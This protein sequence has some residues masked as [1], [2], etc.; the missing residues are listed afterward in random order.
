MAYEAL[1]TPLQLYGHVIIAQRPFKLH[2]GLIFAIWPQG[3]LW[4]HY[5][6]MLAE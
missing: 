6:V 2:I 3:V 4:G 5:G 1:G